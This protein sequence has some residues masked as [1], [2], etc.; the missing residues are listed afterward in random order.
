ME[1][2]RRYELEDRDKAKPE[3]LEE[4]EYL[5]AFLQTTLDAI[6]RQ[7]DNW[8]A[9]RREGSED[10]FARAKVSKRI[11]H[12]RLV[13]V[14]AIRF[15][16][17]RDSFR[18]EDEKRLKQNIDQVKKKTRD[19]IE[20]IEAKLKAAKRFVA[21]NFPDQLEAFYASMDSAEMD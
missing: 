2:E 9:G 19:R 5:E 3:T 6:D 14:R 21:E 12:R 15:K 16:L 20:R 8:M 11:N 4:A 1:K 7:I 10:W 13:T 18:S 17:L